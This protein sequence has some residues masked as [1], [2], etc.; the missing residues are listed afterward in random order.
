MKIIKDLGFETQHN[1][2]KHFNI[3]ECPL[4]LSH[5]KADVSDIKRGRK[6]NCGCKVTLPTLPE[7]INGITVISDLGVINTRRYASFKCPHCPNEFNAIVSNMKANKTRKHCG[8]YIKPLVVKEVKI[9]EKVIKDPIIKVKEHVLYTTWMG[10]RKR[11]YNINH[12]NYKNYGGR[13]IVMC[14]RWF[15]SFTDFANDMGSKPTIKH[16]IDRV[17]NNGMYEPSN[18]RWS[19]MKEQQN[20]KRKCVTH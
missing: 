18:C 7:Q 2:L 12:C 5:F 11:C 13:G 6:K 1:W 3:Y 19:T 14:E 9:K 17:N 15:N 20:N 4:C 10:I 8:C 16:T